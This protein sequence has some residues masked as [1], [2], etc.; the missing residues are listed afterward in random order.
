MK[1]QK[2]KLFIFDFDGTI[3]DTKACVIAAFQESLM[4]QHIQ[5][6]PKKDIVHLMGRS[7]KEVFK[8]LV[9]FRPNEED[10]DRLV[11][12]YRE[13]YS[14]FLPTK[15]FLYKDIEKVLKRLKKRGAFLTI[16]TSKKT[17]SVLENLFYLNIKEYFDVIIGDDMVIKKKPNSEMVYVLLKKMN[18]HEKSDVL[19]IGDST[20]DIEMGRNAGVETC[21]VT[22]GAHKKKELLKSE[23]TYC[24]QSALELLRL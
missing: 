20:Y 24:I 12:S 22:W 23:P 4:Q 17:S 19:V 3:A 1:E 9:P 14:K 8:E 7:L 15:T 21:A 16:A 10:Y 2:H 6:V 11:K 18:I 5:V 13:L